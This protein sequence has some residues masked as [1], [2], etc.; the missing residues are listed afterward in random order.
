LTSTSP[1]QIETSSKKYSLLFKKGWPNFLVFNSWAL[2]SST[3]FINVVILSNIIWPGEEIHV[4]EI[5]VLFGTGTW[6]LA[7]SGLLFGYLTD[8]FSRVKLMILV[9]IMYG[10]SVLLMGFSPEGQGI[11]TFYFFF[12]CNLLRGF[13]MGGIWPI[14]LSYTSDAIEDF[15]RSRFFGALMGAFFIFQS[16]GLLIS[17]SLFQNHF[18][19]EFMWSMGFVYIIVA[20]VIG[21]KATEPKRGSGQN[22]LKK[23]LAE[24][25]VKYHY[26]LT[27][28][29][30]ITTILKPTLIIAF[31]ESIFLTIVFSV[32]DYL[33]ITYIQSPPFNI[34]PFVTTIYL[35]IFGISGGI[36]GSVGFAKLSDKLAKNNFKNRIYL[37]TCAISILFS[38]YIYL[39][40][41]PIPNMT[42]TQGYDLMF[43]MSTPAFWGLGV[44]AFIARSVLGLYNINQPALLQQIN[45]PENQGKVSSFGQFLE[46][47]GYGIGA[48]IAGILLELY[49]QNYQITVVISMII[50]IIGTLFWLL[51]IIWVNKDIEAISLILDQRAGELIE[52]NRL[53][54]IEKKKFKEN[55]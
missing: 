51:G 16:L 46:N 24:S 39:F 8:R 15:D 32:P 14:I 11:F 36:L 52:Y 18:W 30:F 17:T 5:G 3:L 42:P 40:F 28:E 2:T 33:Y 43:V 55:L 13:S 4:G 22:Q 48:I 26:R 12:G 49:N 44:G 34:S 19:R 37:I 6:M 53:K 10:V 29:T 25:D 41:V 35:T 1:D 20:L 45:L 50:G 38:S 21:F 9:M 54:L 23:V 27:K 31:I 47:V 7:I